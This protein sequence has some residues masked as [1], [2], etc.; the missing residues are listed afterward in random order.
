MV[1]VQAVVEKRKER[2]REVNGRKEGEQ[3]RV[4]GEGWKKL[5]EKKVCVGEEGQGVTF[6][7]CADVEIDLLLFRV[8][9][10]LAEKCFHLFLSFN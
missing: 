7:L 5:R 2:R 4:G 10:T 3:R 6:F 8:F 1:S 9:V